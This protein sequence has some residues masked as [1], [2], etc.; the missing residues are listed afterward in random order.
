M[1]FET[2]MSA[3]TSPAP[4]PPRGGELPSFEEVY[5][6]HVE[7][8]WRGLRRLG[9]RDAELDDAVQDVFVVVHRRLSSFEGKS[10][11]KTWL[12]G[13]ALKVARTHRRSRERRPTTELDPGT[14]ASLAS[15]P[16]AHPDRLLEEAEA[17][18]TLYALLDELDEDKREAFVLADLEE[19]SAPE[20]AEALSLN[21]NTVYARIRA[22]RK[23]FEEALVR[24]RA[25]TRRSPP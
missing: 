7:F 17:L 19:L 15:S 3:T 16:A 20:I 8:V 6:E 2:S 23:A 21:L 4:P 22:A 10:S 5:D 13:I 18:R 24:H 25:R 11:L 14:E 12:F 9:V 1:S